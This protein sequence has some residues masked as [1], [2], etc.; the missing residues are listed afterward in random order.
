MIGFAWAALLTIGRG[1]LS[2]ASAGAL[3]LRLSWRSRLAHSHTERLCVPPAAHAAASA[4]AAAA[5]H[6]GPSGFWCRC[7]FSRGA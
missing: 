2:A 1:A 4:H 5:A 7:S 3:A 6:G